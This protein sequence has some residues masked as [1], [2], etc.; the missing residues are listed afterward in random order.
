MVF[1]TPAAIKKTVKNLY[2][3]FAETG[4]TRESC[5]GGSEQ[6]SFGL[7][8]YQQS[9]LSLVPQNAQR[10]IC[11]CG[12]PVSFA[13]IQPC[14]SVVDLGCGCGVDIILAAHKV[15]EQGRVLGID[16]ASEMVERTKQALAETG[17]QHRH[18]F[19]RVA[20]IEQISSLPKTFADFLISNCVINL[21]PDKVA[22]YRNIFRILRPGGLLTLSDIVLTEAINTHLRKRLQS[23]WTGCL[24]GAISEEGLLLILKKSTFID[25]QV[26]DR[27]YLSTEELETIACYPGK[28]FVLPPSQKD[29]LLLEGRVAGIT[30]MARRPPINC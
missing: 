27:Y 30:I 2:G 6:Y 4:L 9:E 1:M 14:S 12:N 19:L 20:D 16:I 28:D 24:G 18:I 21:C 3:K 17:L 13:N 29:L 23:S 25:I 7:G 8:F 26:V 10:F 5:F 22:V 15:G 11:G